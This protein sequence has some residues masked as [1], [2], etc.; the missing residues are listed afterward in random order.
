MAFVKRLDDGG[1]WSLLPYMAL[2][3]AI[4]HLYI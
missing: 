1:M 2:V 4:M 3:F